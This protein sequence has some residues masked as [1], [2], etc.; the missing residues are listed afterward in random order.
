MVLQLR[1]SIPHSES[2][3]SRE[4]KVVAVDFSDGQDVYPQIAEELKDLEIGVLG[5]EMSV[6]F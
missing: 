6:K 4:V 1:T 5:K 3:Y 2:K